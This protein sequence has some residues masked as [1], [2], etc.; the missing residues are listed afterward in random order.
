L[1]RFDDD[2]DDDDVMIDSSCVLVF[3]VVY[4]KNLCMILFFNLLLNFECDVT[5]CLSFFSLISNRRVPTKKR[6]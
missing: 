2:D 6:V 5:V 4:H 1:N 3:E